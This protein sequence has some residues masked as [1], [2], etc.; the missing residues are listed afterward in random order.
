MSRSYHQVQTH[1]SAQIQGSGELVLAGQDVGPL[2][3]FV[4]GD[5]DYEY[6]VTVRP[7]HYAR[8]FEELLRDTA[9]GDLTALLHRYQIEPVPP[10]SPG[11]VAIAR[12]DIG[13]LILLLLR[14]AF[15]A[16]T[17]KSDVEF[18]SWCQ[19][20]GVPTEFSSYA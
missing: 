1:L 15:A 5:S 8:L 10:G 16:G 4:W 19:E 14:E 9:G 20:H 11:E 3:D 6:W 17:F 7:G 13:R 18:R 2:V 12:T